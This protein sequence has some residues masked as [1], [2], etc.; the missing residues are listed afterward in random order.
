MK[1]LA[2][3]A[4]LASASVSGTSYAAT[5]IVTSGTRAVTISSNGPI[6]QSFVATD[7]FLRDFAFQFSTNATATTTGTV[8]F[9]LYLGEGFSGAA[10]TT[11]NISLTGLRARALTDF[12]NV[13]TGNFALVTG[14]TYTAA[15]TASSGVMLGYGPS[16]TSTTD[17]YIGGRMLKTDALDQACLGNQSDQSRSPC[18]ANFRFTTGP[19]IT[20]VPE[21]ASWALMLVGFG[22]TGATLRRRR[23]AARFA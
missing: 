17:A 1:Y 20:A 7:A 18:D 23:I 4:A 14:Q 8:N 21:P 12:V 10:L 6:G 22:L 16:S 15:V 11:Q 2:I 19:A 5:T 9:A 13:Y 3:A